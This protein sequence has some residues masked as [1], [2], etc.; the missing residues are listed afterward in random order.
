MKYK[1]TYTQRNYLYTDFSLSQILVLVCHV[2]SLDPMTKGSK[3][4]MG[5]SP[6]R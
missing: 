5:R 3:N 6:S 4:V 2:I 1:I